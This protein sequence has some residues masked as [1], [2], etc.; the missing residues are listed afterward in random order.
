MLSM[1][2]QQR[3]RDEVSDEIDSKLNSIPFLQLGSP[4]FDLTGKIEFE[5]EEE[6][7]PMITGKFSEFIK[8]ARL[9]PSLWRD[10]AF[11]EGMKRTREAV[12]KFLIKEPPLE[13]EKVLS[14]WRCLKPGV[15][16]VELFERIWLRIEGKQYDW[17]L[18]K[19]D[20]MKSMRYLKKHGFGRNGSYYY[21]KK[22]GADH[23]LYVFVFQNEIK[24]CVAVNG[25][26]IFILQFDK[27]GNVLIR[28]DDTGEFGDLT[29][30]K[31][32]HLEPEEEGE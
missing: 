30:D 13:D 32:I 4:V 28:R 22:S 31:F 18:V 16:N 26:F 27:E 6:K 15:L 23:G 3:W 10:E 12:N 8:N 9:P 14:M 2:L 11:F 5:L 19:F 29:P 24:V 1:S 20:G 7:I 25:K 21:S 17:G